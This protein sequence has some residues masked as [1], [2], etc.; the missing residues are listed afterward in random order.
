MSELDTDSPRTSSQVQTSSLMAAAMAG[1]VRLTPPE[2]LAGPRRR[3]GSVVEDVGLQRR[4]LVGKV[5]WPN[6]LAH[7]SLAPWLQSRRTISATV[8]QFW[9]G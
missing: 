4:S 7:T 1:V 9:P 8:D 2:G 5:L 6:R 3:Q